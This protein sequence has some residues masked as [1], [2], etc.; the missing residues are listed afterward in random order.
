MNLSKPVTVSVV[1]ATYNRAAYLSQCLDSILGQ[2]RPPAEIIVIDDGSTDATPQVAA[3]YADHIRY[4]QKRNQGKAAAL[5]FAMPHVQGTHICMF[6]DDDYM[7]TNALESH[8][9]TLRDHPG[10]DYSYSP[11]LIYDDHPDR[12]I[13]DTQA[14]RK[15]LHRQIAAP[16][17]LLID[18]LLWGRHFLSY[19]QG[20]LVPI[21]CLRE[22]GA[23]DNALLRAQDYDMMLRLAERFQAVSVRTPTF[24]MRNHRGARGPDTAKHSDGNR[25]AVWH[26]YDRKILMPY[27]ERLPLAAY[28]R[29]SVHGDTFNTALTAS[30]RVDALAERAA[31]MFSH[32]LID[33]GL[34]DI[35][36]AARLAQTQ[37]LSESRVLSLLTQAA[38]IE[39]EH[40][41]AEVSRFARVAARN[42]AKLPR[43]QAERRAIATGFYWAANRCLRKGQMN[44]V[45]RFALAIMLVYVPSLTLLFGETMS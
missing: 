29:P 14:W 18:T 25:M 45:A 28:L 13:S 35:C 16:G 39:D 36:A 43:R 30:Q 32:G 5:N 34:A 42:V 9:N 17:D 7:L 33:P 6:D 3:R 2:T 12:P 21:R 15:P 11:N 8:V 10:A 1:V 27:R 41:M 37:G 20:M 26:Q 31:I 4:F 38:N 40:L 22:L 44:H 23:F 24:V 19:L